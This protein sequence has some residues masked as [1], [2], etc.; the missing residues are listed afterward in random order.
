VSQQNLQ[1]NP[2]TV[3]RITQIVTA[4]LITGVLV[5]VYVALATAAGPAPNLPFLS[6]FGIGF[7]VLALIARSIVQASMVAAMKKG[8]AGQSDQ[9]QTVT[10]AGIYQSKTIVGMGVLEGASLMNVVAYMTDRQLWTFGVIACL[11]AMM[12][13]SFPSQGQFESWTQEMKRD[14]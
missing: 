5:M 1:A 9:E 14:L 13:V 7:G 6:Y 8:L 11:L 2:E 3:G 4:A 12:A 10:L